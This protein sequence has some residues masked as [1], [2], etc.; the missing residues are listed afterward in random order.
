M[1]QD[2][3]NMACDVGTHRTQLLPVLFGGDGRDFDFGAGAIVAKGKGQQGRHPRRPKSGHVWAVDAETGKCSGASASAK[4]PPLGG[5][6]WG[7]AADNGL[8]IVP[9][10]DPSS[11]PT[12]VAVESGHLRLR[13]QERQTEM[14]LRRQPNCTGERAGRRDLRRSSTASPQRLLSLMAPW[15]AARSAVKSSSSTAR[16][17]RSSRPSTPSARRR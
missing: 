10:N 13:H 8:V 1:A 14:D 4:A 11:G 6:H 9:I 16:T 2:I 17:E 7:I 5:V 15:S 3:W 12:P